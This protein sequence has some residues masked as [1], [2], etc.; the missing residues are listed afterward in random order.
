MPKK[1][2][3]LLCAGVILALSGCGARVRTVL[4]INRERVEFTRDFEALDFSAVQYS[5]WDVESAVKT[6][7]VHEPKAYTIMIYLNGSDLETDGGEATKD[8]L[9]MLSSGVDTELF[10]IIIFTGGTYR[11]RT[12]AIPADDCVI[13]RLDRDGLARIA[14]AG[15]CNMGDAGTLS[16]FISFTRQ[17]FPAERFGLIFWDHG[18]GSIAGFGHDEIFNDSNLTLLEMDYAFHQAGLD[19]DNL[20]FI[21]FDACLMATVEMAVV[22]SRYARYFIASQDLEPGDGWDYNFLGVLNSNPEMDG[23]K[24]GRAIVDSYMAF[25]GRGT[26]ENLTMSVTDL[27]YVKPVMAAM[28]ELMDHCS[29]SLILD[30]EGAFPVFSRRRHRTK[31][32]G[33]GTRRDN[34]CDMVDTFDMARRLRDIFPEEAAILQNT[35]ENAVVYNRHN[36]LTE[37]GGLSSYYIFGGKRDAENTLG[38]YYALNMSLEYTEYLKKFAGAVAIGVN[39]DEPLE[40]RLSLWR[41]NIMIGQTDDGDMEKDRLWPAIEGEHVCLYR[42]GESVN[43]V[44]YAVPITL[45][46]GAADLIIKFSE[47]YPSGRITGI[48]HEEGYIIQKGVNKLRNGDKIAFCY[49]GANLADWAL[50]ESITVNDGLT[51]DWIPA[52]EGCYTRILVRDI[53]LNEHMQN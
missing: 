42:L 1:I 13:W 27:A 10:N 2:A 11:W 12:Q 50:S 5:P 28:G 52:C 22:S 47:E 17:A 18:G 26:I 16:G 23:A 44:E 34:S 4:P 37:V 6:A 8:I 53:C 21:G 31:T 46:G 25:Y 29:E 19:R 24:L 45:N 40:T 30:W 15:L 39:S 32:F 43:A 9:E 3:L 7:G 49:R 36:L 14:S 41:G 33:V 38:T 48:R 35:L 51:L 20:E